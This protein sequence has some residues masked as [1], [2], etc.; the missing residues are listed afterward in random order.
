MS[1]RGAPFDLKALRRPSLVRSLIWMAAVLGL[2]ALV[3]AG[4][5][6][7]WFFQHSALGRVDASLNERFDDLYAGTTVEPDPQ[8]GPQIIAP[9]LT[10][11][12]ALRVYSGHYW[13]IAEPDGK[14][15]LHVLVPSR[16]LFDA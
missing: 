12:A 6:L 11:Q 4:G 10:D 7:T 14:G 3:T 15:G 5:A 13:E 16:S 1:K 8:N 9:A 2:I